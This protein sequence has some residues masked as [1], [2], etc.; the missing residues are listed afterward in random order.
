MSLVQKHGKIL[1][2]V[3]LLVSVGLARR[4]R[5]RSIVARSACFDHQ[6][7]NVL[8]VDGSRVSDLILRG[9][10]LYAAVVKRSMGNVYTSSF[11]VGMLKMGTFESRLKD[12]HS[13]I[14]KE[15]TKGSDTLVLFSVGTTHEKG[16]VDELR[17]GLVDD[18]YQELAG[19]LRLYGM[20]KFLSMAHGCRQPY[21]L[22]HDLRASKTISERTGMCGGTLCAKA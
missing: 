6:M 16:V 11:H 21:I 9:K 12:M 19:I 2:L 7:G 1:L 4:N 15:K 20:K 3:A 22:I 14:Q 8:E 13:F 10:G 18:E 5:K 17:N